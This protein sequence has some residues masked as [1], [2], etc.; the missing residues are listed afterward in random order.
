MLGANR[1]LDG[2][3]NEAKFQVALLGFQ[4][5]KNVGGSKVILEGDSMVVVQAL[6]NNMISAWHLG[7]FLFCVNEEL[8]S[9]EDFKICHVYR[10]AN[11]E[12]D[13]LSKWAAEDLVEGPFWF[14]WCSLWEGVF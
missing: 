4:C 3:N 13:K 6:K 11:K 7:N 10:E 5:L 8:M 9:L 2:T 12:A 1:L 14:E